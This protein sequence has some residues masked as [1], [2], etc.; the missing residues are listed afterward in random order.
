MKQ[1]SV[2]VCP[3]MYTYVC[4]CASVCVR[5]CVYLSACAHTCSSTSVCVCM[6]VW[7]ECVC[8]VTMASRYSI[9]HV[10]PHVTDRSSSTGSVL[11]LCTGKN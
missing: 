9:I 11:P 2:S 5:M 4:T 6:Y 7:H 8:V 1:Y 10:D 3:S